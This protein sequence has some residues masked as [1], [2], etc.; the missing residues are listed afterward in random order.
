[1]LKK[2]FNLINT[3]HLDPFTFKKAIL[4]CLFVLGVWYAVEFLLYMFN[5]YFGI[6]PDILLL[7]V[8]LLVV[9]MMGKNELREIL[10]W[11]NVP[12]S[13]FFSILVMF[14][15]FEIIK[16]ELN[17]MLQNIFP[18]PDSFFEGTFYEPDNFFLIILSNALFPGFTEEIMFRG[19]I[20]RRFYRTYSPMKT[21]LLSAALFGIYHLNPW[22][23]VNAFYAGIFYCW[24]Y[25]RFKSI[26]LC[27]F[28]H[29][30]HNVLILYMLRP[31]VSINVYSDTWRHPLWFD[32]I[33][34]FL[35]SF[36]LLS[37]IVLSRKKII[38]K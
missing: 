35:F 24:I 30:Y 33:G 21:I 27:M 5:I 22:Q 4:L 13:I 28:T 19:I 9:R 38:R 2:L 16:S 36:G 7:L 3:V 15:G 26:W 1:M 23:A 12:L 31:Y 10:V 37:V 20:A 34:L 25:L 6:I 29:A 14:F 11:R 17:N 18:V 8:I 32:I